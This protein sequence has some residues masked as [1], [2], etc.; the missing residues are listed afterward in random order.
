[1]ENKQ[2]NSE[3]SSGKKS[4]AK[5]LEDLHKKALEKDDDG[6]EDF[7]QRLSDQVEA[8]Q[9]KLSG[10]NEDIR[11]PKLPITTFL[12][13]HMEEFNLIKAKKP[14]WTPNQ[15]SKSLKQLWVG[16]SDA[17]KQRYIDAY[18]HDFS[19]YQRLIS[20]FEKLT[21]KPKKPITPYFQFFSENL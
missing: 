8:F 21:Q 12:R 19:K 11:R 13:Y 9:N 7:K 6:F 15:I 3:P 10:G 18:E 1:M 20:D 16:M 17:K 2:V 5:V 14:E 4:N